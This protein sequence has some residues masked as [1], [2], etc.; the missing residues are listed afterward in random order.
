MSVSKTSAN[1]VQRLWLLFPM[2]I[3]YLLIILPY[4]VEADSSTNVTNVGAIINFSSRI[5]KEQKTA[6]EIAAESF[7]NLS[8]THKLILHFR[9]SG[10]DPF[11]AA[12]AAE[13]LIKEKKVEVIVGMDTWEEAA[14]V[15]DLV[16]NQTQI[17]VISFAAPSITPPLMQHRWPF[18]IRIATDGYAQMKCIADIVSAYHWKTVVV[19]YE[20]DGYG[21]DVG[22]LALLTEALQD[23]GSKIEHRLVLPQIS[24]LSNPNWVELEEMLRL[25]T[26][27]SR[28]FIILQS[29]LPTVT[30]LFRLAGKMGLVGKESAW[31]ITESIA[32]LLEPQHTSD[33]KGTLG[34]R[35]F[36][37]NNTSSYTNFRKKFQTKYSEGNSAQP[38]IYAL[39]A[40][41]AIGIITQAIGK[42]T[43]NTISL[44]VL[45]TVLSSYTGLSANMRLNSGE[46]LSSPV[47]RIVN[48][49]DENRFQELNYWAPELGFSSDEAGENKFSD[50]GGVIWPGNLTGAPKGWAMPTVDKPMRIG[51][52][53][54]TYFS[55]FVKVDL[56]RQDSD[57]KKYVGF[58]IAIFDMVINRLNYSLPYEFEVFDGLHDDLVER[59]HKKVY[60]A[61]VA[62]ITVLADRLDKVEFTQPY[63]ESG[64]SMIVPAKPEKSTWM[65]MKPF[66][67]QMWVV[68]G[69]I[70]IYTV[71]IIWFLERPL[72]PAFGGPLKNQ[73][74]TA[75]WFTFSSLFFA[76][77]EKIYSNLTRVV[78]IVWLFVVLSLTSSYTANL[79]SMLTVQRL[80][81]NAT[82]IDTNSKVG[83]DGDSFVIEY[84]QNVLGFKNII[85]VKSEYNYPNE[86]KKKTIEAAFLELPYA[87]VFMNEYCEGYTATAPTY[88]FGGLSFIFQRGSPIVRDF[89]KVIL[90]LLENGEVK[91]LQNEWL[92]PKKECPRNATSNEPESLTLNSFT[93]LY[94]ISAATSTLCFLLSFT[95]RLRRFQ[96]QEAAQQGSAS[97]SPTRETLSNKA[98]RMAKKIY[99]RQIDVPTRAPFFTFFAEEWSSPMWEYSTTSTTQHPHHT[100]NP[101]EIECIPIQ[102]NPPTEI[103][104]TGSIPLN[105][106][107]SF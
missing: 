70:F 44:E 92:T 51:V 106:R 50:V 57:K 34:I 103:N 27:Q 71:F 31:I 33:M 55:K 20:D 96:H 77:K 79:S 97:P 2:V 61:V 12:S 9:D 6:M 8:K 78:V 87:E 36:Y 62:D 13:E 25:P 83:C 95:I 21:G 63:M 46:V 75:T 16:G 24:S 28:V 99:T 82:Y 101:T 22:M 89:S 81:P 26:M 104:P 49:L 102:S 64:L 88:R 107:S 94:V 15:A 19:V 59:V 60:D 32:S 105:H 39:R 7:N 90:E 74:G 5:G 30:N 1:R 17:P 66:T 65:F 53:G 69:S 56:S 54:N 18:L 35:T 10:R 86:F 37:A 4:G 100:Y 40:Y 98:V 80:K 23:V 84:L 47:F 3:I 68:T 43:D 45:K 29:S 48:I 76:H 91:K 14:Q 85:K 93:G 42:M 67:L 72:N 73:I 58:C 11:L 52:P 38:E 41:D